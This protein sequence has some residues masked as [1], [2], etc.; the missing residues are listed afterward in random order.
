MI[1]RKGIT[2]ALVIGAAAHGISKGIGEADI[3]G[4]VYELAT[5][6]PNIDEEIFGTNVGMREL[7]LPFPRIPV[8][9]TRGID[10][11]RMGQMRQ[12]GFLGLSSAWSAGL[13][14]GTMITDM[15]RNNQKPFSPQSSGAP[16]VDGSLVFGLKNSSLA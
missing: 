4:S 3:S 12:G 9:G 6:N 11:T 15:N 1:S 14:N 10:L 5:G 13:I 2:S 16:R 8:P 7:L